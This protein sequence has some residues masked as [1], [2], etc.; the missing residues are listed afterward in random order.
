MKNNNLKLLVLG[1]G[2]SGKDTVSEYIKSRTNLKYTPTSEILAQKVIYPILSDRYSSWEECLKDRSNRRAE[3]FQ[4]L[5]EYNK[6]NPA[7]FLLEV[8]EENDIYCGL[9]SKIELQYAIVYGK[10]DLIIWVDASERL[11]VE[12]SSSMNIPKYVADFIIDN[13]GDLEELYFKLDRIIKCFDD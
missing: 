3:W 11:P 4:I 8:L 10:I 9:R 1:H 2:R 12:D 7:R 6:S 5:S 13:N